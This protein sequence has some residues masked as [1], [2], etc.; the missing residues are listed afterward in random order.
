[1]ITSIVGGMECTFAAVGDYDEYDSSSD[2]YDRHTHRYDQC[3]TA[4]DGKRIP[5][6]VLA[7]MTCLVFLTHF[8]LFVGACIDT[9]KR[10]A[11][12]RARVMIVQQPYWGPMAQGWQPIA[13]GQ[14]QPKGQNGQ[15]MAVNQ[16]DIQM[17]NRTPSPMITEPKGKEREVVPESSTQG[18]QGTQGTQET[19]QV[20]EYYA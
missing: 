6:T 8:I 20:R 16:H 14:E 13:Q 19:H 18:V 15:Y 7:V 5:F 11:F 12:N 1:M 9:A 17:Q 4:M 10:N 3:E 2:C